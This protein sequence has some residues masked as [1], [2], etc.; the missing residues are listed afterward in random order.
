M[1]FSK[2]LLRV[3]KSYGFTLILFTTNEGEKLE[4]IKEDLKNRN[5][6]FNLLNE[7]QLMKTRKPC[8]N[9]VLDDGASI[10]NH[11]II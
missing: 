7:N 11:V 10:R 1:R 8:Y 6:P 2:R 5:I 3:C 4:R 9:I